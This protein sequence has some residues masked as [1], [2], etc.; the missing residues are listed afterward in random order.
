MSQY[1]KDQTLTFLNII[2]IFTSLFVD[3]HTPLTDHHHCKNYTSSDHLI[4][5]QPGGPEVRFPFRLKDHHRNLCGATPPGF[6]LYCSVD[7]IPKT[8]LHLPFPQTPFFVKA[9]NTHHVK[10][11]RGIF[12]QPTLLMYIS[13]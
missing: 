6:D 3:S 12:S 11:E 1:Q 8:L 10:G 2:F 9:I 5:C 13:E 4:R 7:N